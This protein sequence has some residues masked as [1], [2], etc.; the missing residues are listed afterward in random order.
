MKVLLMDSETTPIISCAFAQSE[1]M[2]KEVF[3][4]ERIDNGRSIE[5]MKN[6]KCIVFVRPTSD[7]I[8]RIMQELQEPRFSQYYLHF[9]NAIS[10]NEVKRLAES[11]KTETVRE[12]QEVF[13]D[14]IPL[15]KDLFTLNINHIYDTE[16]S[17][18][19]EAINRIKHGIVSLILQLKKKPAVRYQKN[20]TN[21]KTIAEEVSQF[22]RRENLLF[23]NAKSDTVLL[24]IERS[25]D[26]VTPLLNQWTYEAMIHELL[27]IKN[28]RCSCSEQ[29]IVLSEQHDEFFAQNITSNFGEIGQNIKTLINKFQQQKNINK[30]LESIQDMK[31]FVEDYPQF[32]KISGT[33][34]KHVSLVGELS[35]FV[36]EYNLLEISEVEQAI[37]SEGDHSKCIDRVRGLMK[38]PGTRSLDAARL[39]L[40]YAI[41]FEKFPGNETAM[42]INQLKQ[43]DS[44]LPNIVMRALTYGGSTKRPTDLF[45]GQSTMDITKRFIKGL[46]GVEN[47]Y[48]QH[49]PYLQNIIE[50]CQRGR[51]E[52]FSLIGLDCERMDNLI[53]FII[54]GATYEEAAIVRYSNQR[55]MQG[56]G[57]PAIVLA[58]NCMLNT[59]S[60]LEE[61][62]TFA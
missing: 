30:N 54:G 45:G 44:K 17:I 49:S 46:K 56:H 59:E 47:I 48:T 7:N 51:F 38:K 61:F 37:V 6:L 35:K 1:V 33:V 41:R 12:V 43:H 42:L 50:H 40:L 2:Q 23:E 22:F 24:V 62:K 60:F 26:I 9:S 21:C 58:G 16:F 28:N 25:Q 27:N 3:L 14:G 5:N 20:S 52:N 32:K 57:G 4:F 53:V 13:L 31:K 15:R 29:I 36:Q 39:V 19:E 34:S 11:D 55:R 10:K 8:Q 18:K